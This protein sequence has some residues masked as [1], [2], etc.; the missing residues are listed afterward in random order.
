MNMEPKDFQEF[1]KK[2]R[3]VGEKVETDKDLV[4]SEQ[5]VR[6]V[7]VFPL[8]NCLGYDTQNATKVKRE[9][10]VQGGRKQDFVDAVFFRDDGKAY[11]AVECKRK[12]E[13]LDDKAQKQLGSYFIRLPGAKFGILTNGV[14]YLFYGDGE[15]KQMESE[16]FFEFDI[17]RLKESDFE[18]LQHFRAEVEPKD[19][20]AAAVGLRCKAL[21]SRNIRREMFNPSNDF[22]A[23]LTAKSAGKKPLKEQLAELAKETL[24]RFMEE[25]AAEKF[26]S[27]TEAQDSASYEAVVAG[28][29]LNVIQG[30]L[31]G[32]CKSKRVV[33]RE[34]AFGVAVYLDDNKNKS[35]AYLEIKG[36]NGKPRFCLGRAYV[37]SKKGA[38]DGADSLLPHAQEIR[39]VVEFYD[40]KRPNPPALWETKSAPTPEEEPAT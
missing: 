29:F 17:T 22:V 28:A 20:L 15:D 33:P 7:L 12:D 4:T 21:M 18:A 40:G 37:G 23:I 10:P 27:D 8:F 39:E 31:L 30:M 5:D 36:R 35:I 16:P 11:I 26:R 19:V 24:K 38:Y 2:I 34:T 14:R 6:H 1:V 32:V 3:K 9:F 25:Q 13:K